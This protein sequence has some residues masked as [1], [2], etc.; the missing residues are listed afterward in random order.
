TGPVHVAEWGTYVTSTNVSDEQATILAKTEVRNR[1]DREQD[2]VVRSTA[3][4]PSG[5]PAGA[6]EN[7]RLTLSVRATKIISTTLTIPKPQRWDIDHPFLYTLKT[8]ILSGDHV[9]DEYTTIFGVRTIAFNPKDGFLLNG[10]ARKL[11]GVCLHH[12]LGA[13]GTAVN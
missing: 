9:V 11:H 8:E 6:S 7:T 1:S 3:F 10:K 12:D 4:D 2:I 13:L 5:K